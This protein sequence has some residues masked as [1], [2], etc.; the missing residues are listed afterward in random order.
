MPT[1]AASTGQAIP[2]RSVA[3]DVDRSRSL[4]S[5]RVRAVQ[6]G[7][8]FLF[9]TG[10]A[11][12]AAV[13]TRAPLPGEP[14]ATC[15][16]PIDW[17]T[18]GASSP[19]EM[20]NYDSIQAGLSP[21][22]G[23]DPL[24]SET[25]L[26]IT[27]DGVVDRACLR[28]SSGDP[29]FDRAALAAAWDLRFGPATTDG[30]PRSTRATIP[31]TAGTPSTSRPPQAD[32]GSSGPVGEGSESVLFL[33]CAEAP[34]WDVE[35]SGAAPVLLNADEVIASLE[36][37]VPPEARPATATVRLRVTREGAADRACISQGSGHIEFDRAV[38]LVALM[39]RFRPARLE[40]EPRTVL[41]EVPISLSR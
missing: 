27:R 9:V 15:A 1:P 41:V 8:A 39:L 19:P 35:G 26:R 5:P 11:G 13:E 18:D 31:F 33:D 36:R 10:C 30:E 37:R 29:G 2:P 16:Q 22:F 21:R 32:S 20:I 3:L 34:G 17:T 23:P 24:R 25:T 14:L 38:L 6:V 4:R 28:R 12:G 7:A 40:G